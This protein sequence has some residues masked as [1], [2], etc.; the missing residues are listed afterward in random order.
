MLRMKMFQARWRFIHAR[1]S[2][3]VGWFLVLLNLNS[4]IPRSTL[5]LLTGNENISQGHGIDVA[6]YYDDHLAPISFAAKHLCKKVLL[7]FAPA[8]CR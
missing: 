3:R 4:A 5:K 2:R 7:P 1:P 8:I 6:I